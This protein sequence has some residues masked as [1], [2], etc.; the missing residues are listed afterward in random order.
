MPEAFIDVHG[1][2]DVT[3]RKVSTLRQKTSK[4]TIPYWKKL[5]TREVRFLRSELALWAKG[6][7]EGGFRGYVP[8][9]APE[10]LTH[11]QEP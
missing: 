7:L 11:H 6:E 10:D 5:R 1:A 4:G 9:G 8:L 3:D 2:A